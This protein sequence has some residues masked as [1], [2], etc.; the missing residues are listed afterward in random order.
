M[1]SAKNLVLTGWSKKTYYFWLLLRAE[2]KV[3]SKKLILFDE[4]GSN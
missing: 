3:F 1:K 4:G 2:E